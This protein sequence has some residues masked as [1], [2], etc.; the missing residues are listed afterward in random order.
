MTKNLES[1]IEPYVVALPNLNIDEV[2]EYLD[3]EKIGITLASSEADAIGNC[4]FRQLSRQNGR[5]VMVQIREILK[6]YERFAMSM[7]FSARN[8][9]PE[10]IH[11]SK[12]I[13]VGAF[14]SGVYGGKDSSYE[15]QARE[16]I[17]K[18][19]EMRH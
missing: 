6:G 10:N 13:N 14:L 16:I 12:V 8:L 18:V 11:Y 7:T 9:I 2:P 15:K 17:R 19:G 4:L 1:Y 5:I 3:I